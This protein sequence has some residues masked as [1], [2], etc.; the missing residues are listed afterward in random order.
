VLSTRSGLWHTYREQIARKCSIY[1]RTLANES[2]RQV[3]GGG[4]LRVW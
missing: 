4:Q 2:P 3:I 1:S